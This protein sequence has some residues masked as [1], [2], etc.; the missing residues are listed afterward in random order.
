MAA[1]VIVHGSNGVCGSTAACR[2]DI[3]CLISNNS[4]FDSFF[5][6]ALL[7]Q[8][9]RMGH[10][11]SHVVLSHSKCVNCSD[12]SMVLR[13]LQLH[14]VTA[15]RTFHIMAVLCGPCI[16]LMWDT[17]QLHARELLFKQGHL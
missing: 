13:I 5:I 12:L 11:V 14:Q 7:K 6:I 4:K 8:Q 1:D 2:S 3:E 9:L 15:V 16:Y 10:M 17:C